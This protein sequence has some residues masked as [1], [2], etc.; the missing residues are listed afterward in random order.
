MKKRDAR[1]VPSLQVCAASAAT[2]ALAVAVARLL[3][4]AEEFLVAHDRL[5]RMGLFHVRHIGI[6][7]R[8]ADHQAHALPE[9]AAG[10]CERAEHHCTSAAAGAGTYGVSLALGRLIRFACSAV[11]MPYTSTATTTN[12]KKP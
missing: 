11:R 6:V 4:L 2:A 9:V 3:A 7:F 12:M 8:Q 10:L 1:G 5:V